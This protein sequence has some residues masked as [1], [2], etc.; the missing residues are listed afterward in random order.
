MK[1]LNAG[2][3]AI[4]LTI[5]CILPSNVA[6]AAGLS[7]GRISVVMPQ[8]S[9]EVKGSGYSADEVVAKLGTEKLN[10]DGMHKYD[11]ADSVCAYIL[12][13]LSGSVKKSFNL[14]KENINSYVDNMG[15]DDKLIILT[16]G[17]TK[18]KTAATGSTSTLAA[19]GK[20]RRD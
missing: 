2:I 1:R 12:V 16:F 10:V 7:L 13:D 19:S 14:I 5:M 4:I 3:I 15:D 18:V 20:Q 11:E 9:V 8:V 6:K 17:E